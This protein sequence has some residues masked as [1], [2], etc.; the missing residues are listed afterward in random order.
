MWS[1]LGFAVVTALVKVVVGDG[2]EQMNCYVYIASV[3]FGRHG[4]L[5][6]DLQ[7][8]PQPEPTSH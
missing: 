3:V 8:S 1:T 2:G 7:Q 6:D 5:T 4:H